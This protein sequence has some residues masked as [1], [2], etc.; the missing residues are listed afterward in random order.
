MKIKYV[1]IILILFLGF[2]VNGQ[3]RSV[4]G[5]VIS[6]DLEPLAGVQIRN[7]D[8]ELV[9]ETDFDGRF[10]IVISQKNDSLLFCFTGME[11]ADIKLKEDCENIEVIM[12]YDV[13]YDFMKSNKIDRLRKKRYD[14][15]DELY[16]L[17]IDKKLFQN[18]DICYER[19]FKAHKPELDRIGRELKELDRIN[20]ND[21]KNLKIGDTVRIPFGLDTTK[22]AISINYSICKNCTYQ[23]YDFLIKGVI[24]NKQ[25]KYLTLEI[26]ITEMLPYEYLEYRGNILKVGSEFKYEMKY[27][28]V[29]ID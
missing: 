8:N 27:F 29:L 23:D 2:F 7:S 14:K 10:K 9:G 26:K 25:R 17:A 21:F 28:E 13:I 4:Y 11:F 19:V 16:L 24:V 5:K 12:M 18:I 3:N 20:K 22:K 1:I 15:L 6:E